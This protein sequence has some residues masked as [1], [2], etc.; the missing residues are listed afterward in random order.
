MNNIG[1]IIRELRK[2]HQISQSQLAEGI[3]SAKYLYLIEKGERTPS[4]EIMGELG[5]KLGE[6][7]FA[8][9]DYLSCADPIPVRQLVEAFKRCHLRSSY[10]DLPGLVEEALK[11]QDFHKEPLSYEIILQRGT[12]LL[13]VEHNAQASKALAQEALRSMQPLWIDTVYYF[14]HQNLLAKS[15][16][17]LKEWEEACRLSSLLIQ[18]LLKV[19]SLSN[20]KQL[21][22]STY[23]DFLMIH[24]AAGQYGEVMQKGLELQR[25][26]D[27]WILTYYSAQLYFSLAYAY[28]KTGSKED[29]GRML[30]KG[31]LFSLLYDKKKTIEEINGLGMIDELLKHHELDVNLIQSFLNKYNGAISAGDDWHC[32]TAPTRPESYQRRRHRP[33]QCPAV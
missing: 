22:L 4:H 21:V 7:L 14:Y 13:H 6:D 11:L 10:S 5:R 19:Q 30:E 25:L 26:Q 1:K 3:C 28:H 29:C 15:Q 18:S 9:S 33:V 16:M 20:N 31:V 27:E 23:S 2:G 12:Y 32:C 24:I 17:A 8:F